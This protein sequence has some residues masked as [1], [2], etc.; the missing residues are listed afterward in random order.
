MAG[1]R[2]HPIL[3]LNSS[4]YFPVRVGRGGQGGGR[5]SANG[6]ARDW[7]A[8]SVVKI[9][10][11]KMYFLHQQHVLRQLGADEEYEQDTWW[12]G[13]VGWSFLTSVS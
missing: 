2:R 9:V 3:L 7:E 1:R 12:L 11:L 5:K 6:P 10:I 4:D 13:N 8:G